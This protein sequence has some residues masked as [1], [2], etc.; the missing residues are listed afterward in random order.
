MKQYLLN[1]L[2]SLCTIIVLG[3]SSYIEVFLFDWKP[4]IEVGILNVIVLFGIF[5][6]VRTLQLSVEE[7]YERKFAH[8]DN[9]C[10]RQ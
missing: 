10:L 1:V 5:Y 2:F 9:I 3:L 8:R 4:S 6:A 7:H